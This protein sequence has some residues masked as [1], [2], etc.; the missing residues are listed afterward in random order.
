MVLQAQQPI[1]AEAEDTSILDSLLCP[2]RVKISFPDRWLLKDR[3][4]I[5]KGILN[6]ESQFIDY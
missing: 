2:G 1:Q 4:R 6:Y 5:Y 3:H